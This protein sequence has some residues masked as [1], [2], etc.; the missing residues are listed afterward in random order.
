MSDTPAHTNVKNIA[1][2]IGSLRKGSFNRQVANAIVEKLA[3][4]APNFSV[5]EVQIADLPLYNQDFDEQTID[6]YERVREQ[7]RNADGILIV[8][9]EHNRTMPSALKNLIDI[10]SRPAGKSMWDGKKCAVV[11][12]SPGTYGGINSALDVRK[13]MQAL[14]VQMM[15]KPEVY[16][17][18][19]TDSLTDGKV[20]N[21]KTVQFLGSFAESFV[22]F[23]N[24]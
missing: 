11:T 1:L 17:S 4:V 8:T 16:L 23:I 21:D 6:S 22:T 19:V 20:S 7:I 10:A 18:R 14:G 13:S 3:T 24:Q 15:I 2:I 5:N 12:A 9:P